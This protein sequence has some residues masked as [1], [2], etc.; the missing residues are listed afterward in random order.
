MTKP[1]CKWMN[2]LLSLCAVAC[3][4]KALAS[5]A[6]F[7]CTAYVY[8]GVPFLTTYLKINADGR[9]DNSADVE[10]FG[11]RK[12]VPVYT[13][14]TNAGERFH[15]LIGDQ[16]DQLRL[17]IYDA[18]QSATSWTGKLI[19]DQSPAMKEMPATCTTPS[20]DNNQ[21]DLEA[22]HATRS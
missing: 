11:Q 18:P 5:T 12:R 6:S 9:I 13:A 2:W 19:N 22:T 14:A 1:R 4:S 7:N 3:A 10:H 8:D 17:I 21:D 20:A 15:L 16:G